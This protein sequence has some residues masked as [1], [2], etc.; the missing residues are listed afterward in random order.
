MYGLGEKSGWQWEFGQRQDNRFGVI[1]TAHF[2]VPANGEP[3]TAEVFLSRL[4][5]VLG[6]YLGFLYY[7]LPVNANPKS[8][9]Y[10][11]MA[12]IDDLDSI[13]EDF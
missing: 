5:K 8:L 10:S 1:S 7:H 13:S 4:R 11:Q 2:I 12:G 6:R 3:V 9:M